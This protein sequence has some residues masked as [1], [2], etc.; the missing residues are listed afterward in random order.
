MGPAGPG[1]LMMGQPPQMQPPPNA[2]VPVNPSSP[3]QMVNA[4]SQGAQYP[5][6]QP[7]IMHPNHHQP[8]LKMNAA[9]QPVPVDQQNGHP[10]MG[11]GG[12]AGPMGPPHMMGPPGIAPPAA[13]RIAEPTAHMM[14]QPQAGLQHPGILRSMVPPSS[15]PLSS[16]SSSSEHSL[17]Q[18]GPQPT[19]SAPSATSTPLPEE[20]ED[21][22]ELISFD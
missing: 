8:H 11:P 4:P 1:A 9:G 3:G 20:K 16:P 19:P 15:S 10:M 13:N 6:A 18:H 21:V 14:G 12:M 5:M 22:A 2:Y 7:P 17:I